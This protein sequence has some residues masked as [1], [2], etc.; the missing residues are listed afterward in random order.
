MSYDFFFTRPYQSLKIDR[1]SDVATALLL[2]GIGLLTSALVGFAHRSREQSLRSRQEVTRLHRIAELAAGGADVE[3][4]LLSVRAELLGL[5]SL[6]ECRFEQP[7]FESVLPRIERNGT[8][9]KGRRR[10]IAGEFTLPAEGAEIEVLGGGHSWGRFVLIPDWDV[11]V[12]IEERVVAIALVDQLGA[13]F[14]TAP[15]PSRSA[16]GTVS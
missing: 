14:A 9:E 10:W 15:G 7:P 16:E 5:L 6:R 1:A 4:V 8:I 12:S 13:A 11:G 2:L 3:D